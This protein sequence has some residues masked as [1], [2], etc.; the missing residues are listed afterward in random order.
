M[1]LQ[2]ILQLI[3]KSK[4]LIS[5][6]VCSICTLVF[7]TGVFLYSMESNPI[8]LNIDLEHKIF[9]FVPQGWAF[10]TRNPREAQIIIYKK[11]NEQI[12]EI[13]QRHS[14]YQN[15]F[16]LNR[17]ASK[18]MSELQFI[19]NGLNDSLF[20]NTKWNYQ[21]KIYNKIPTKP[22]CVKNQMEEPI[23]CGNYIIVFQKTIPW[24]WS[25]SIEKIEMP[26]KIINLNIEC[27]D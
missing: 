15:L 12:S 11:E 10:F 17:K 9:T 22:I 2:N 25:K 21:E 5:F 24:A 26:A 8:K 27:D 20:D 16:G 4:F 6:I 3:N 19:K 1:K 13:A 14:A 23:L 7:L 18:I